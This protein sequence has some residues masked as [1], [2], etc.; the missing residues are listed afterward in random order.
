MVSH[1]KHFYLAS[2]LT[3]VVA[4]SGCGGGSSS[5]MPTTPTPPPGGATPTTVSIAMGA[6]S[7]TTTAYVPDSVKVPIGGTVNWTNNDVI[8]H[9]VNSTTNVFS[10]PI[11]EAGATFSQTFM[12]AGTFPYYCTLHVGMTGTVTVQ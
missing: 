2:F 3:C 7:L 5:P 8:A 9:N 4:L 10:S 12:T 11:M 6:A 1:M